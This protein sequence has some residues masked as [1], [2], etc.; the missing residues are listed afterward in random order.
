MFKLK[1]RER[2]SVTVEAAISL[3]TF[4]FAIVT[5]LTIMNICIVQAKISVAINSAA[6]ELSQ[7]SYLYAITGL[8]ESHSAISKSAEETKKD[9]DSTVSDVN[10]VFTE[11]QNLGNST[12]KLEAQDYSGFLNDVEASAANVKDSAGSL[13]NT[14]TKMAEDPK[15]VAFGIAKIA[16][17]D[18]LNFAMSKLVAEP[19]SKVLCKKNLVSTKGGEVE[20]YL[21][22]LG[23][24]PSA[25]GSYMDGLDFSGST[26]FPDGSNEI[27]VH[28]E[29]KVKAIS[30]L[31]IDA[32]FT[33]S[34]TAITHGWLAGENSYRT[35]K[36]VLGEESNV[37]IWTKGTLSERT[38]L[39]RH[40]GVK[41]L[42]KEGYSKVTGASYQDIQLYNATTNEFAA[43]HSM[44]PLYS[45]EGAPSLTLDDINESVIQSQIETL[46]SGIS[47]TAASLTSVQVKKSDGSKDPNAKPCA[48]ATSR[49]VL[50]IPQD[51]GLQEKIQTI[52][53]KSNTQGVTVELVSNYGNGARTTEVKD[54]S[55]SEEGEG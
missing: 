45:A 19:L 18:G 5:I 11:I 8:N 35:L 10:A 51:E 54:D 30:L 17:N 52:I 13:K 26:I 2:G 25:T 48:N 32:T 42:E 7:Y 37:N 9:I 12:E 20:E 22:G 4:M 38:D 16:A 21:K 44:N 39:I 43:V 47:D 36:E 28:V 23:V 15:G 24:V 3:T 1:N 53:D 40:Q 34:Q 50:V 31:P 14:V 49:I 33:F 27:K 41:E 46:C 55:K 29:Y 6:K